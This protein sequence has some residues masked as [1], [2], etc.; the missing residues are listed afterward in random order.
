MT[1]EQKQRLEQT[2]AEAGF[3]V[4]WTM[5]D[6]HG[7]VCQL[8]MRAAGAADWLPVLAERA[9]MI[10]KAL[11]GGWTLASAPAPATAPAPVNALPSAAEKVA[12]EAGGEPAAQAVREALGDVPAGEY[13]TIDAS[14][15]VI[16][17][18]PEG[19][20]TLEFYADG[21]NFPDL[22]ASKIKSDRAAGLLKHVTSADVSKAADM[23]LKCRL[24]YKDG[25]EYKPGQHYKD[26]E[27]VRP[28]A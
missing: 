28:V 4:N 23:A 8:T 12:R 22:R 17:P 13:K 15:L 18:E 24:Y 20:V 5:R 3:S 2:I 10:E 21:H 1:E 11:A 6:K 25:K 14:R 9:A 7:V 27:H 26:L 16:R 19:R